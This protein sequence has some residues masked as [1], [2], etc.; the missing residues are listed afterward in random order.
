MGWVS[1]VQRFPR[2]GAV[3]VGKLVRE[4]ALL[5]V[6]VRV[7]VLLIVARL[8]ITLVPMRYVTRHL[9]SAGVETPRGGVP[10]MGL[11][12]ARRVGAMIRRLAPYTPTDSNCYPQA[13]VA[14]WMLSRRGIPTTYY[15]GARFDT[16]GGSLDAHV[17]VRC[18][19][20]LVTGGLV[21]PY[22]P[23]TMY[24]NESPR[25]SIWHRRVRSAYE[26]VL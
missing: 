4:P 17:W 7:Y 11:R 19:P 25:P 24:A 8:V 3:A 16:E 22:K 18:G 9:G 14:W 10:A 12:Y 15:Y 6:A 21:A 13:L 1:K 23:L 20:L 2:R 5:V 26:P